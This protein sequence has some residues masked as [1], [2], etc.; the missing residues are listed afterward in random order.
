MALGS[1]LDP[2]AAAPRWQKILLGV[3]VLALIT[4]GMYFGLVSPL[5]MTVSTLKNQHASLQVELAQARAAADDVAR[6]RRE[7]AELG[8]QLDGLKERLPSEKEMPPLYRTI[9]DAAFQSGLAVALFQPRDGKIRDYYVEYPITLNAEGGY[10]QLGEF[11]ER[12]AALPRVVTVQELKVTALS[13]AK[14][15][16]RAELTLATYTYRP[17]GSPPAPK[18]AQPGAKP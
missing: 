8:R 3:M 9:T 15:P 17:V 5:E 18:P 2:I 4:A 11:F 14:H 1:I 10:H 7:A 12:V 13:K 16:I 6:G